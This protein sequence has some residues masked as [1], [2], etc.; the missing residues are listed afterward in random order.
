MMAPAL[1][2]ED[3]RALLD[4]HFSA[5]TKAE[6]VAVD[7]AL[8]RRA[9]RDI[10][11]EVNL[12]E[13]VNAAVDGYGIA[14]DDLADHPT[15]PFPIIGTAKAGHPLT[16]AVPKGSA[17]RIFTGAVMPAGI[18]CVMM[19]EFCDETDGHVTFR[20]SM[21]SGKN[22]RPAGENLQ[23]GEVI[24]TTGEL[25]TPAHIGQLAAAGITDIDV[26]VPLKVAVLSTGDELVLSGQSE[27]K[28]V[29][30]IYDSNRPMVTAMIEKAG[31]QVIDGGIIPDRADALIAALD[32][33]C[34]T[35]DVVITTGGA[36]DG[37]EDHTKTAFDAM[38]A[39]TLSRFVAIKPG[40]P[41]SSASKGDTALFSLPGNPVAVYVCFLLFVQPVLQKKMANVPFALSE[42]HVP[43]GFTVSK[44]ANERAEFVR[45]SLSLTKDGQTVLLPYGRKGAGVLSS[46]TGADGLAELPFES[47]QINQGDMLRFIPFQ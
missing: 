1:R 16:R 2:Y 9:F 38:G 36:A 7:A 37:I 25:I 20:K 28:V 47:Q 29:G 8:G 3:V 10:L 18:D 17:V 21:S 41:F 31:C 32:H 33:Y 15:K 34:A 22:A 46:L 43:S 24:I 27:G 23:K 19:Q 44:P 13:T 12:P 40:R 14:A 11:S 42:L 45:V 5:Q 35:C 4:Q 26:C 6:T 39:Q 30:Q